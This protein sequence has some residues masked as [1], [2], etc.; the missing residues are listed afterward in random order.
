MKFI[1]VDT[2][3]SPKLER[4]LRS[5]QFFAIPMEVIGVGRPYPYHGVKIQYIVEY[6]AAQDPDETVMFVDGY[7]V[8]FLTGSEEI[9]RK[10]KSLGHQALF[11]TEQNC[12]VDGG[13]RT[14]FPT[15]YRYPKGKKPYRFINTGSFVGKAGYLRELF[16]RLQVQ[17]SDCEQTI[18]NRYFTEH[19]TEF[20]LDYDQEIFTCTAG[21]TGLEE[22]DYR[23]ESGRIRNTITDSLPCILH[24]PGKNYIGLEKL[25]SKLPFAG[26]PY[27][28]TPE[29]ER[30]YRKSQFMNR[31]TARL[32]PD[33]FLFHLILDSTLV[34][35]GVCA[36]IAILAGLIWV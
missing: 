35:L 25:V 28:P 11:S 8:V 36:S 22:E 29:E 26:A 7:D 19:S 9:E 13:L 27:Q 20:A 24:C 18:L 31:I 10:F 1:T 12:N 16:S 4:L 17:P 23:I 15:W 21:R 3:A 5:C 14:R 6:L 34:G 30:K 2:A 33:N 32:L